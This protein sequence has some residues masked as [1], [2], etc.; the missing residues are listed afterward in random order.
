MPEPTHIAGWDIGGAHIKLAYLD[1]DSLVVQQ[2]SCPLWQG[3]AQLTAVLP[4]LLK[5]LPAQID[6]HHIT[7][8]GELV[9]CFS[10]RQQGV[11][12]I[13]EACEHTA[14]GKIKIFSVE[15]LISS[16][17]AYAQPHLVASMNWLASA[18][19]LAEKHEHAVLVD[20][21]STTTDILGIRN[22]Q[23][24]NSAYTDFERLLSG[25]LVYTGVVRSCV[26]TLAQSVEFKSHR[27]PLIAENFAVTADIYRILNKLPAHADLGASMDGQAK[28][29]QASLVR[30]ARMLGL[31]Y[32]SSD[33]PDWYAVAAYLMHKQKQK[34]EQQL[35][36]YEQDQQ[37]QML[38]AA[39]V[40]RFLVE[41]IASDMHV[42]V[43]SFCQTIVNSDIDCPPHA[44]DCAPAVALLF[45]AD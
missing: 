38:V 31:D 26:N 37:I 2:V 10:D 19:A 45:Q 13:I 42:K 41:E 35:Q 3:I 16:Q 11:R 44:D 43:H 22:H 4:T 14:A 39:G 36:S 34:I 33:Y 29:E 9:D 23:L 21:G 32:V 15:G 25:A 6:T 30:L 17:Q 20:I 40:G 18:R 12:A 1:A 24:Q 7:M 27:V 5:Q 8:T 28:N